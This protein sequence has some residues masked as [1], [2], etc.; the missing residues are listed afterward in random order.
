VRSSRESIAEKLF[1]A[2]VREHHQ[3]LLAFACS[4][5]GELNTAE[6]LVQDALVIS[7]RK[8][9][10]FD[11]SRDFGSWVRGIIKMKYLEY[12]RRRREIPLDNLVVEQISEVHQQWDG[13]AREEGGD[14]FQRLAGCLE[15]LESVSRGMVE[16][17]YVKNARSED[18]A[19]EYKLQPATVR[20]RLERIRAGLRYCLE[21]KPTA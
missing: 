16:M 4:L 18:I 9:G 20:K 8:L 12:M 11:S 14:V 7:Y 15:K 21:Q 13:D 5:T 3:R 1:E 17:F 6:D 2:M 10:E 19:R